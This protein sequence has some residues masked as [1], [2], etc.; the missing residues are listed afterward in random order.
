MS[1]SSAPWLIAAGTRPEIVKLAPV[2]AALRAAGAAVIWVHTGQHHRGDEMADGLYRFF[3]IAPD[4]TLAIE[5]RGD[6]PAELQSLLLGKLTAL[7]AGLLSSPSL[8]GVVVQ[9][10]TTSTL[11]A[12]QAAH[13]NGVPVAHVEAGLRTHDLADPFPEEMNR[14]LT[15]Q[16]ARWHF[17]PTAG[18]ALNLQREGIANEAIHVVGNTAVDA[19]RHGVA[20]L[21]PRAASA[22]RR[23]LV[24]AHRRENWGA[25]LARI[26]R[27]VARLVD[28]DAHGDLSVLWPLHGNPAVAGA[29]RAALPRIPSR[30]LLVPPLDYP[31]LL[32]HLREATLVLTDSGG[33][34][35]EGAALS[36]PVAVLRA[37]T[38]RPEL[39][40]SGGG[41]LLGTDEARIVEVTSRLLAD[42]AALQTMREAANPFGDGR[43]AERIVAVLHSPAA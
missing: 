28:A 20:R 30:L 15:A 42:P 33:L 1:S 5:R 25:G 9:G 31:T 41:V 38:E 29:V 36:V 43:A 17:A 8:R 13:F 11:A 10:D 37:S 18:A 26:A 32:H 19:A 6:T 3:G 35:E 2:H 40:D 22:G 14:V 39:I 21:P 16:L 34:Q 4:H 24:T 27:A 12:A 23:L 7:F